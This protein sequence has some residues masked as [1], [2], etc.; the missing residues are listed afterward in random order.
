MRV[1]DENFFSIEGAIHSLLCLLL[2]CY[3]LCRALRRGQAQKTLRE[4]ITGSRY[5]KN[6][7]NERL[8]ACARL[9]TG[10]QAYSAAC[11]LRRQT[12]KRNE[13]VRDVTQH[14]P[15]ARGNV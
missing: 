6:R 3:D 7:N 11:I 1:D 4:R 13:T 2:W 15:Y 14:I 12:T 9:S 8:L 5:R 10:V